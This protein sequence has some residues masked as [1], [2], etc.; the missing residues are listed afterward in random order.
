[1]IVSKKHID[2]SYF[3]SLSCPG[4]ETFLEIIDLYSL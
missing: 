3:K 2:E 4:K 1:M